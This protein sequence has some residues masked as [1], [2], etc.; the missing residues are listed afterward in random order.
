MSHENINLIDKIKSR[1][2]TG[3]ISTHL[4]ELDEI[5]EDPKNQVLLGAAFRRSKVVV[6][7]SGH[8][9]FLVTLNTNLKQN[10]TRMN[11]NYRS[12]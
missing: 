12:L 4:F 7:S 10:K 1:G 6:V 8:K 9:V 2:I 11:L 3:A 5:E